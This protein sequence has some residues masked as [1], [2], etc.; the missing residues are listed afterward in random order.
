[1]YLDGPPDF[2]SNMLITV[3]VKQSHT[4]L[5]LCQNKKDQTFVGMHRF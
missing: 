2:D 1:M 5:K 4:L 3:R